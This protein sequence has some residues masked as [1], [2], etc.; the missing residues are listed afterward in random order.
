MAQTRA[1]TTDDAA[2]PDLSEYG[3]LT[4]LANELA[5]MGSHRQGVTF[6]MAADRFEEAAG[7]GS[8]PDLLDVFE[9]AVRDTTPQ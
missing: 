2:S 8:I 9:A 5:G 4:L 6:R 7:S 1:T 3:R